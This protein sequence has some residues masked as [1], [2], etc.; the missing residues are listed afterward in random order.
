MGLEE[1]GLIITVSKN[2][3]RFLA[4]SH[5]RLL[6]AKCLKYSFFRAGIK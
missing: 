4:Y 5:S 3:S 2:G 1:F 6:Y